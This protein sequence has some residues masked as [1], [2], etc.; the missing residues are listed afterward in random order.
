MQVKDLTIDLFS[1]LVTKPYFEREL[2]HAG[3]QEARERNLCPVEAGTLLS[4]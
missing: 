1:E 2:N 4:S 3:C